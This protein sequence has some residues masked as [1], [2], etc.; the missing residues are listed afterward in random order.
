MG[1]FAKIKCVLTSLLAIY[2]VYLFAYKCEQLNESTFEH[3]V[4]SVLHP[5]SHTHSQACDALYKGHAYVQPYLDSAHKFLDTHVHSHPL[6]VQF[7]VES[8]IACL[9]AHYYKYVHHLVIQLFKYIEV[10]EVYAYDTA[11]AWYKKAEKTTK[12]AAKEA[13]DKLN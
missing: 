4:E 1:A 12:E 10:A 5:L 11:L 2:A 9:K 3:S 8:K 7:K 6:F 13:A